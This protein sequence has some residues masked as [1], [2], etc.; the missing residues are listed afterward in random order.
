MAD[1]QHIL[2]TSQLL[3]ILKHKP[4]VIK[5]EES[6]K[7][8]FI[9]DQYA[10]HDRNTLKVINESLHVIT[11]NNYLPHRD[12]F[13]VHSLCLQHFDMHCYNGKDSC[14]INLFVLQE[15]ISEEHICFCIDRLQFHL[16]LLEQTRHA[17]NIVS[18]TTA[19][20]ESICRDP[21]TSLSAFMHTCSQVA[22]SIPE[23][24]PVLSVPV[25]A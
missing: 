14:R 25:K 3:N 16:W 4:K 18:V 15:H 21:K 24:P 6:A 12:Q 13:G 5:H 23:N 11:Y 22:L 10:H 2:S 7:L 19:S 17:A 20:I 1:V 8:I 9:K